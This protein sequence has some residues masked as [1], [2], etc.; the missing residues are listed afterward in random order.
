MDVILGSTTF[1]KVFAC[2]G[3]QEAQIDFIRH[4]TRQ[5]QFRSLNIEE[6]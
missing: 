1:S 5:E 2:L 3:S 6:H 4:I